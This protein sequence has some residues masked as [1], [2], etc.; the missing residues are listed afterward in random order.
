MNTAPARRS[1]PCSSV[2][3]GQNAITKTCRSGGFPSKEVR[4]ERLPGNCSEGKKPF[5]FG[6]LLFPPHPR[7]QLTLR[8]QAFPG[9]AS[10]FKTEVPGKYHATYCSIKSYLRSIVAVPEMCLKTSVLE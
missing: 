4:T 5:P 10:V 7:M 9:R 2:P 3:T 1:Y 6:G 8:G